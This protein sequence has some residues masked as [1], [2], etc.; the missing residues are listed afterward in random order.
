MLGAVVSLIA[1]SALIADQMLA[2]DG[3]ETNV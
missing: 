2:A 1:G 3:G